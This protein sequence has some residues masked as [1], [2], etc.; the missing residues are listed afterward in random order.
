MS[1]R[2]KHLPLVENKLK[3]E[4]W[5]WCH[6]IYLLEFCKKLDGDA[7]QRYDKLV[8][9]LNAGYCFFFFFLWL[10]HIC[11]ALQV[12]FRSVVSTSKDLQFSVEVSEKCI[13]LL[14]YELFWNL[15]FLFSRW[16]LLFSFFFSSKI[17]I[18][19]LFFVTIDG[20]MFLRWCW[21]SLY[22]FMECGPLEVRYGWY[23]DVLPI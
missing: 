4:K 14:F 2:I 15:H 22:K 3:L 6:H 12:E 7:A 21:N 1:L 9:G 5:T 17:F 18:Y 23:V 13:S 10:H 11:P 16:I 8:S 20:Y 19:F